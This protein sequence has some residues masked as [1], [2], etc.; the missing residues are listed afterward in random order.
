MS[1]SG[2][3]AHHQNGIIEKRIRDLQDLTRTS[4]LYA[5]TRWPDAVNVYLWPY[6]LLKSNVALNCTVP[7]GH[8][9]TP[10]EKFTGVRVRPSMRN[11]HPFGCPAY[12]LDGPLQNSMKGKKWSSRARLGVYLGQSQQY[13]RKVSLI[14]SLNSGLVSPQY[15]VVHDDEF[16]TLSKYASNSIPLSQWQIKCGFAESSTTTTGKLDK[17]TDVVDSTNVRR[18]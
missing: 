12:V 18:T 17:M 2:V 14:L 8:E 6:A 15:H 10:I 9:E 3:G 1:Y 7:T 11:E 4:L 5:S 16:S 13:S